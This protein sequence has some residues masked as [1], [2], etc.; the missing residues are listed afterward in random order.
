MAAL[1]DTK[2]RS[3]K[4]RPKL[5]R[6]A[7]MEGLCLEVRPTGARAWRYRYRFL[8]KANMLHLGDYPAMSLQEARRERDRQRDLL[9]RGVDP[10][11]VRRQAKVLAQVAAD[12]SFEGVAR[13]WMSKQGK[14]SDATRS[15]VVWMLETY[16]FPWIGKR[17]IGSIT[18]PEMLLLLRRPESLGKLETAQRLKQSSGQVFRYAIGTGRADRDPTADLRGVLTTVHVQHHASI[19]HKPSVGQLMRDIEA[20]TGQLVT[21]CGLQL[22]ALVFVRPGELRQWEWS[23]ISEDGSE[24]R[25]P[26]EK[27]KMGV[28]HIVPLS[29]QA[30]AVLDELRPLTG[31]GRYVFPSLR[32]PSR[33]MSEN[34]IN[35]ALRRMGYASNQMTAHGFRSMASTILNEEG[36]NG[37]WIERQLA[38]CEKDG[39]RAAYNYAQHLPERRKMM[40]AWADLLDRLRRGGEVV[41][42]TRRAADRGTR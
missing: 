27:M 2:I 12:D 4:P 23:E 7:D 36:F 6:V 14:W 38:H 21:R 22:S 37:D 18:T 29:R 31:R 13:E 39:V 30:Q 15:K 26:G 25:I 35:A 40:Q 34:T 10:A 11:D 32:G 24:W 42:I 20:F 17:P 8:G 28:T 19:T 3:L 33:P 16:A 1:T 5:Y 9:A 41:D